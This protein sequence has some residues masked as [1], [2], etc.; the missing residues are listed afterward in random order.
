M[1][2]FDRIIGTIIGIAA[3]VMGVIGIFSG[4]LG[5][6][7][8]L[9]TIVAYIIFGVFFILLDYML[10]AEAFQSFTEWLTESE[11]AGVVN[12]WIMIGCISAALA[13]GGSKLMSSSG[14][15]EKISA[16]AQHRDTPTVVE[17]KKESSAISGIF[18][19]IS[20]LTQ[21]SDTT[22]VVEEKEEASTIAE[23][24]T[25]VSNQPCDTLN[26]IQNE[27]SEVECL[28]TEFTPLDVE[29]LKS[30]GES[31]YSYYQQSAMPN[32]ASVRA[33]SELTGNYY[34]KNVLDD[35]R[36]AWVEGKDDNGIGET[37]TITFG[38][39]N[40]EIKDLYIANGYVKSEKAFFNNSR[41]KTM[42]LYCD[43]SSLGEI[44]FPDKIGIMHV[45][46]NNAIGKESNEISFEIVDIYE[47]EKFK[48]TAISL[49]A[50]GK[51]SVSGDSIDMK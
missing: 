8:D 49:I 42:N 22:T 4:D 50:F 5:T 33:S 46:L 10:P 24:Q 32:I 23:P 29:A 41:V 34:A 38:P 26:V 19:K 15:F 2:T 39:G 14:V 12:K 43:G 37:I 35:F 48:D 17:E 16:W 51:P 11:F 28:S 18:K 40:K 7:E 13:W 9:K 45:G 36:T 44:S 20:A 31:W 25:I 47:G 27:I 1:E 21:S 6:V 30:Q 3:V